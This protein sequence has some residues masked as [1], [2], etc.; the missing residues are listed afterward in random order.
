M[1]SLPSTRGSD[2]SHGVPS[3]EPQAFESSGDQLLLGGSSHFLDPG[4]HA[5]SLTPVAYLLLKYKGQGLPASKVFGAPVAAVFRQP[6]GH[7]GRNAGVEVS[8]T[9]LHDVKIPGVCPSVVRACQ[10]RR[11]WLSDSPFLRAER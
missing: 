8:V 7:I 1:S 10:V 9:T 5:Q 6:A 2:C 3:R 4:F 11:Q